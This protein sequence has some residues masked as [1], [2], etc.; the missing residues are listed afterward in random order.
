MPVNLIQYSRTVGIF[1]SQ[2]FLFNLKHKSQSVLVNSHSNDFSPYACFFRHS[3]LLF[4]FL[5]VFL[6]LKLNSGK[7]SN[8]SRVSPFLVAV[9]KTWLA[10]WFYSLLLLLSG[11]VELLQHL[12]DLPLESKRYICSQ[13]C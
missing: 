3:V 7:R 13:L 12:F 8:D 9:I 5:A 11:D 1:N 4:L 10:I 6:I 2:R